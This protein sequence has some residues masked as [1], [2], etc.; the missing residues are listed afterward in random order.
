MSTERLDTAYQ[1]LQSRADDAHAFAGSA[2]AVSRD[3]ISLPPKGFGTGEYGESTRPI[4]PDSI[5]LVASVTKPLTA[6]AAVLLVERGALALDDRV[7]DIVPEF[8]QRAKDGV[9][10]VHLLTHT[11]GL[12]DMLPNNE[13]LR[14]QH[15]SF[16]RF[17]K[18]ICQCGL[19][20]EP[21]T[22]VRYQ[23][24]GTAILGEI[25]QRLSGR[26]LPAFLQDEV[27][28][29]VGMSSTSLGIRDDLANRVVDVRLPE[30]QRGTNWHWNSDY[31]RRFGA[32]WGGM[33]ASVGDLVRLLQLFLSGGQLDGTRVLSTASAT[34]MITDQT[35]RMPA[36]S[37]EDRAHNRWGLGWRL[38]SWGDLGSAQSFS[39]GGATG[40]LVGADPT[41]GLSCAI[42]TTQPGAP[43]Q[44][45]VNAVQGALQ[46]CS[47]PGD[48]SE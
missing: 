24:M 33:Y 21:G 5:F 19:L 35:N 26:S 14:Q 25:V 44:Y 8:A 40:T 39:H 36:L 12:P 2:I 9:R 43:L 13:E 42:F 20:F 17:V 22:Q 18:G 29:P 23:S 31:W 28:V 46:T 48:R 41:S 7:S 11:S 3:G 27:F 10:V 47:R 4:A 1:I 15:A 30:A 38:G 45:V 32:P 16:D 34:A 37:A 6:L